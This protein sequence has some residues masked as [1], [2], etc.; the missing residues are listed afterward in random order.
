LQTTRWRGLESLTVRMAGEMRLESAVPL[1]VK[2]LHEHDDLL[3]EEGERALWK[4][5]TDDVVEAVGADY[6]QADW[7]YRLF[8]NSVLECIHS[9][10]TVAKCLELLPN[11]EDTDLRVWLGQAFATAIFI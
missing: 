7:S 8:A 10:L 2:K 4:I 1:I 9:D 5:G 11:E 6:V 3:H